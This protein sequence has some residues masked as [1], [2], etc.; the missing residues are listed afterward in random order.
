MSALVGQSKS[1]T[2]VVCHICSQPGHDVKADCPLKPQRRDHNSRKTIQSEENRKRK[3]PFLLTLTIQHENRKQ[4][5]CRPMESRSQT[6]SLPYLVDKVILASCHGWLVLGS[7]FVNYEE[8]CLWNPGS[9]AMIKLPNKNARYY[10]NKCVLSK[11][12]T[13]PDCH[14]L[15]YS[16]DR[17]GYG[18]ISFCKIGDDK[19]VDERHQLIATAS[20]QGKIYGITNPGYKFVIIEFVR[21]KIEFRQI[22]MLDREQPFKAP[23]V[24]RNW[25]LRHKIELIN[26]PFDDEL[27]MVIKDFTHHNYRVTDD[28]EYRVFRVDINRMKCIEVDDIGDYAI[29]IGYNG[30][31]FCC[32]SS[33]A[34][35]F[36]PNSIYY[37]PENGTYFYVYDFDEKSTTS[38]LP[39]DVANIIISCNCWLHL[40]DLSC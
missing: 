18:Q 3:L 30:N 39:P 36:K 12:P 19:Y 7:M 10:F 14:I 20:F 11:P 38:C 9:K 16:T 5:I 13:E 6:I 2:V 31:G 22:L 32:S 40:K 17:F 1:E 23:V 25:V 15:F 24:K 27:L 26:S 33:V 21:G 8:S 35:T 34:N 4:S 29:L 28:L 37:T